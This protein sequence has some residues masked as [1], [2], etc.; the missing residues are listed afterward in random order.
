MQNESPETFNFAFPSRRLT[1]AKRKCK[2]SEM[3]NESPETFDF[4]FPSRRLT[5]AKRK[6]KASEMQNKLRKL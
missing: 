3:Q 6:C 1:C 2:A 5:C 4:A